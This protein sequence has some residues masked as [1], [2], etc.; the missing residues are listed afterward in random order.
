M[1]E[2]FNENT[3]GQEDLGHKPEILSDEEQLK[4][5]AKEFKEAWHDESWWERRT[6]GEK[7]VMGIGFGIL[8]LGFLVLL[9]FITMWLWNWLMPEIFGL[10]TIDYW[11]TWGLLLLSFIFFKNWGGDGDD[12]KSSRRRK[13]HLKKYIKEQATEK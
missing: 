12:E 6:L 2:K 4:Q 7:I 13:K 3:E 9:G 10:T 1:S 5:A 11:Q 8:F